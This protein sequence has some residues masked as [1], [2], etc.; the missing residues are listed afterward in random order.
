M[1]ILFSYSLITSESR[2]YGL[3]QAGTVRVWGFTG[4][5]ENHLGSGFESRI[6]IESKLPFHVRFSC[7]FDYPV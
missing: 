1:G 2:V 5:R 3:Q 4:V 6:P 7:P